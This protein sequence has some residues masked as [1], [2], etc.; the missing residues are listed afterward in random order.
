[1]LKYSHIFKEEKERAFGIFQLSLQLRAPLGSLRAPAYAQHLRN[2][3]LQSR[4]GKIEHRQGKF[5]LCARTVYPVFSPRKPRRNAR[6]LHQCRLRRLL[7]GKQCPAHH[8]FRQIDGRAFRIE[9][10]PLQREMCIRDRV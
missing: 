3:I 4:Q 2:G 5:R 8:A 10:P 9:A 7:F 6:K 1:M